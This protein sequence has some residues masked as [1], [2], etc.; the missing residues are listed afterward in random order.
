M[1]MSESLKKDSIFSVLNSPVFKS[2]LHSAMI[3][4]RRNNREYAF[5]A[6]K[7]LGENKCELS[8]IIAGKRT[9]VPMP[10]YRI[11]GKYPMLIFHTHPRKSE[12]ILSVED[13]SMLEHIMLYSQKNGIATRP[14]GCV[15]KYA[16]MKQLRKHAIHLVFAQRLRKVSENSV[17]RT[18]QTTKSLHEWYGSIIPAEESSEFYKNYVRQNYRLGVAFYYSNNGKL[19]LWNYGGKIF[20]INRAP[21]RLDNILDDFEWRTR[22]VNK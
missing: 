6:Y 5:S 8:N 9:S 14:I 13:F 15:G 16:Y 20:P 22:K 2:Q 1:A 21:V 10:F 4:T 17:R 7:C 11:N 12:Q 18:C 3:R 19:T